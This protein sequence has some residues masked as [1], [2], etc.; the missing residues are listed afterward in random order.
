VPYS[1]FAEKQITHNPLDN[2]RDICLSLPLVTE[3]FPFDKSTLVWKVS[4]KMFCLGNIDN[5]VSINLKC[6][7][8]RALELRERY[9]Q[10]VPGWHMNKTLW[11]TVYFDGLPENLIAEL[12]FHSYEEVVRKLPLKK[13]SEIQQ[14]RK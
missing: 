10:I 13:Q 3:E 5:F 12:I 6:N 11:N 4:G 8:E 2:I 7:P 14:L 9:P 1:S